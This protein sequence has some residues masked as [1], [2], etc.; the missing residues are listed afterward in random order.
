MCIRDSYDLRKFNF[1]NRVIPIWNSLSDHVVS[2]ERVNTFKN[3]L[4]RYY[5]SNQD[6]LYHYRA[7][8]HGIRNRTIA[9]QLPVFYVIY[10]VFWMYFSDREV[11]GGMLLYPPCD[12]DDDDE[13]SARPESSMM[14][15]GV[16]KNFT[17][18]DKNAC[19]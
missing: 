9:M 17:K 7:D 16:L 13:S 4:D 8:L 18:L 5:W 19:T 15:Y 2:A 11:F 10:V 12:D 3:G 1:A 6:V 14:M